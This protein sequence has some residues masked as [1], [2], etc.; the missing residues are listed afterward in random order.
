MKWYAI[1][2]SKSKFWNQLAGL[3]IPSHFEAIIVQRAFFEIV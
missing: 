2:V 3:A 1:G